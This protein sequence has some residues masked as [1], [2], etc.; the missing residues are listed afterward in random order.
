M[1]SAQIVSGAVVWLPVWGQPGTHAGWQ[2]LDGERGKEEEHLEEA[3]WAAIPWATEPAQGH[4][5]AAEVSPCP[6][7]LCCCLQAAP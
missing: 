4:S 2:L 1:C 7:E 3:A 6:S 5:C